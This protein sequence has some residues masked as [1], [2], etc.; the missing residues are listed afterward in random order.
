MIK[1]RCVKCNQKLGVP[2]EWSGKRIR[3]S[4]CSEPN[5]VPRPQPSAE[6]THVSIT[7]S[8][9]VAGDEGTQDIGA[10]NLLDV[11][12]KDLP[13]SDDLGDPILSQE[14]IPISEYRMAGRVEDTSFRRLSLPKGVLLIPFSVLTSLICAVAAALLWAYLSSILGWRLN[15]LAVLVAASAGFG[16]VAV[17]RK[18]HFGIGLVS[19]CI[20]LVGIVCGKYFVSRWTLMPQFQK[21]MQQGLDILDSQTIPPRQMSRMVN[22]P[23]IVYD[24]V[25]MQ[26]SKEGH[27]SHEI[28]I[29]IVKQNR[30]G[31]IP[32]ADSAEIASAQERIQAAIKEWPDP[33]KVD[34][35]RTYYYPLQREMVEQALESKAGKA[36][37]KTAAFLRSFSLFDLIWLPMSIWV[38][39]RIG[40][41]TEGIPA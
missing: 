41:V 3:C 14:H 5:Q 23:D 4:R 15:G 8:A 31:T 16:L 13:R 20:G 6:T 26:L 12:G 27:Y 25:C 34:A 11:Q 28:A 1:F 39:F 24:S 21:T 9:P 40:A 22:E 2:D 33:N 7:P 35:I 29:Q 36:L 30:Q 19:V 32:T 10:M 38:A 37:T 17:Q 18:Q